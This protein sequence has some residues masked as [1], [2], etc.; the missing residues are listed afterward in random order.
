M[1]KVNYKYVKLFLFI[2]AV[3]TCTHTHIS[4]KLLDVMLHLLWL[5]LTPQR[6]QVQVRSGDTPCRRMKHR[7][8]IYT[9]TESEGENGYITLAMKAA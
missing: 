9:Q 7:S 5:N 1:I 6:L 3:H 8:E 2:R 4:I